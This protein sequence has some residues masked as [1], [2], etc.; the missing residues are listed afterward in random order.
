MS[1]FDVRFHVDGNQNESTDESTRR[2]NL[3][4]TRP[5]SEQ[6]S[7][8]RKANSVRSHSSF[9]YNSQHVNNIRSS[10]AVDFR[11][12]H[13]FARINSSFI[14]NP[15]IYN[16]INRNKFR[17]KSTQ[18]IKANKTNDVLTDSQEPFDMTKPKR[19]LWTLTRIGFVFFGIEMIF[20]IEIALAVPILLKLKVSEE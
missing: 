11:C 4:T 7:S 6:Y 15:F 16:S 2:V 18:S 14:R 19:S 3:L 12:H 5:T 17:S 10:T 13:S 20:S 1:S 8:I 9:Q